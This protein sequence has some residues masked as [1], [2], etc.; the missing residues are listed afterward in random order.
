MIIFLFIENFIKNRCVQQISICT[1]QVFEDTGLST[2]ALS[3]HKAR[4]SAL[5]GSMCIETT[6]F[7]E[8]RGLLET[9]HLWKA[10]AVD[11]KA[12]RPNAFL[13]LSRY[14]RGHRKSAL[15][16]TGMS[17]SVV[18]CRLTQYLHCL[19]ASTQP[20]VDLRHVPVHAWEKNSSIPKSH[21]TVSSSD[22][23]WR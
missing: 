5:K 16:V 21:A 19:H 11:V 7:R 2:K 9:P 10:D 18:K 12:C 14:N 6:F 23:D 1:G 15:A 20:G 3:D 4:L 8:E 17:E 13:T 22:V